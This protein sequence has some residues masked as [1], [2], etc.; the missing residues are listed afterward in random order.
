MESLK[1]AIDEENELYIW[2]GTNSPIAFTE[3]DLTELK[4]GVESILNGKLK[5][6][7][8]NREKYKT[9]EI[10]QEKERY[11]LLGSKGHYLCN[12]NDLKRLIR[13]L[14]IYLE[15][16]FTKHFHPIDF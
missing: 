3:V 6:Y 5:S 8:L 9:F 13:F 16:G 2:K 15:T 4:E 10:K 7:S 12:E 14:R 1:V 11:L